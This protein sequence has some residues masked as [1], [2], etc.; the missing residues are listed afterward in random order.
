ME[1]DEGDYSEFDD[2][3]IDDDNGGSQ[4]NQSDSRLTQYMMINKV[5]S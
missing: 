3:T 5:N 1:E 2:E 4:S